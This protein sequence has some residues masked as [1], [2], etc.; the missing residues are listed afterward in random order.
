MFFAFLSLCGTCPFAS[1]CHGLLKLAATSQFPSDNRRFGCHIR[2]LHHLDAYGGTRAQVHVEGDFPFV[3]DF[4][5]LSRG[6]FDI[7]T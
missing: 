3:L 7:H 1:G 5:G 2:A 6:E 4:L